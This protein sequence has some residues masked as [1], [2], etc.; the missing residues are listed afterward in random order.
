M[1]VLV[2]LSFFGSFDLAIA[3][4]MEGDSKPTLLKDASGIETGSDI[5]LIVGHKK[6]KD[7]WI[8]IGFGFIETSDTVAVPISIFD[9]VFSTDYDRL[10]VGFIDHSR[11]VPTMK[12]VF[13]I[14]KIII[15]NNS[16]KIKVRGILS[17]H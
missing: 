6:D 7:V 4:K 2:S 5:V 17:V 3:S 13:P 8:V 1:L 11:K 16:A 15:G 14:V 9:F 10:A 12:N